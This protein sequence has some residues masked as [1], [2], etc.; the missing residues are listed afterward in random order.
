MGKILTTQEKVIKH[1][2]KDIVIH[3]FF[4]KR[5]CILLFGPPFSG[6]HNILSRSIKESLTKKTAMLFIITDLSPDEHFKLL[7]NK[8][9]S[10]VRSQINYIDCYSNHTA[11]PEDDKQR[12]R[13]VTGPAALSEISI[14][15]SERIDAIKN[16]DFDSLVIVFDSL[17]TILLYVALP[18]V[19]RFLQAI[20]RKIKD[21]ATNIFFLMEEGMHDENSDV[22]IKHL[23]EHIIF[24]K[25]TGNTIYFKTSGKDNQRNKLSI[26]QA[27]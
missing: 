24:T 21:T 19:T 20:L 6:K 12:I 26:D 8:N 4:E 15:I 14:A 13:R 5:K 22:S 3:D 18:D 2:S 9:G 1:G 10:S 7:F 16:E 11:D 25:K 23:V 17:S 27:P